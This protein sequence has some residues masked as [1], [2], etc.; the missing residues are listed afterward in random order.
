MKDVCKFILFVKSHVKK[1]D[2]VNSDKMFRIEFQ[3]IST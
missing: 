3:G 2:T 1:L